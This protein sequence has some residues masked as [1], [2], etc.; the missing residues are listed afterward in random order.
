MGWIATIV[1][2]FIAGFYFVYMDGVDGVMF[3]TLINFLAS[4][5]LYITAKVIDLLVYFIDMLPNLPEAG[6]YVNTFLD[7]IRVFNTFVPV[8][9]TCFALGLTVVFLLSFITI[10]LILKMIPTIG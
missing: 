9:E 10:K 3:R 8:V 7:S 4:V 5:F 2:S 6:A 1:S